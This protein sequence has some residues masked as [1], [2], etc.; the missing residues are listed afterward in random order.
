M[1]AL[2]LFP[3]DVRSPDLAGCHFSALSNSERPERFSA[4][5]LTCGDWFLHQISLSVSRDYCE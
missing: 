1:Y 5:K 3:D 2:E 4:G